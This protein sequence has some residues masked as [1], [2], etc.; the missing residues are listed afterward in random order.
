MGA[1]TRVSAAVLVVAAGVY[2]VT[3]TPRAESPALPVVEPPVADVELVDAALVPAAEDPAAEAVR[4][5]L[6]A[7]EPPVGVSAVRGTHVL[8]VIVEGITEEDARMTT[9]RL[10]GVDERAKWPAEVR[11]S[12]PCEGLTSD[13]DLNPF[14]ARVAERDGD[15]R[16]LELEVE[17][18]HPLHFLET[19]RV[20]LSSGV[21]QESGKTVHEIRVQLVPAAVMHG[22]LVRKNGDPASEGLVG[23]LLLDDGYPVDDV[24]GAVEC[25]ANGTFELRVGATGRYAL[26]SFEEGLRPTT[27]QVEALVGTRI[28]VGTLVLEPGHSIT[29][30]VLSQGNPFTGAS[31]YSSPPRWRTAAT[32]EVIDSGMRVNVYEGRTFATPAR[33]VHLLWLTPNTNHK[34]LLGPRRGGRFELKRQWVDVDEN[35]AF[36][37][38][39]LGSLEYLLRVGNLAEANASLGEAW[40]AERQDGM[41]IINGDKP[42]LAVRAPEH[43]VVLE[44][45]ETS[46]RFELAGDLDA[47]DE[48]RLVLRTKSRHATPVDENGTDLRLVA[49]P[50]AKGL[51]FMPEILTGQFSLSGDEPTYVLQAPPNKHM[52]GEVAFPGRRPVSL[53][54]TTPEPGGEL[55]IPIRLGRAEELA[56]LV[57]ELETPPAEIPELFTV[58]LWRAGLE[59]APPR[60]Q[61]VEVVEGQLRVEGI[62]PDKYRVHVRPGVHRDYPTGL[63]FESQLDLELPPGRV[64]TRSIML[65]Q[66]AGLRL[67]VRDEGG[68]LVGGEFDFINDLGGRAN[69]T[70]E[71]GE[72]QRR[73]YSYLS[74]YPYGTHESV[75]PLHPGRY[76]LVL[77]SP[78]YANHSVTVE[79]RAGEYEDVDVTLFE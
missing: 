31:V 33:S 66:C 17:V 11:D 32:P 6:V 5:S 58:L 62:H 7:E 1:K 63:F 78:G 29:G 34:S 67:T 64:V 41:I 71:V 55:V 15:L 51:A 12:W 26:A 68:A 9:V 13:F 19:T 38:G 30:H 10:T 48:G 16:A 21:E 74:F 54:F 57:I 40:A 77:I 43:G 23:G 50:L 45:R 37:F 56:T 8:R 24:D 61:Q 75:N 73:G 4:R 60:T 65:E 79:L 42:A 20:A 72:G 36:V 76:R 69:L 3:Q 53:D 44:F 59:D 70:M 47:E 25:A 22:R 14:F 39:G 27:T 52:T 46:I 18:D 28:D 2:F 49:D 35:G